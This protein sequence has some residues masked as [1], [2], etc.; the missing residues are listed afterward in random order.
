MS[1]AIAYEVT[2]PVMA[3][4][5]EVIPPGRRYTDPAEIPAGVATRR[6]VV[7]ESPRLARVHPGSFDDVPEVASE[8][9][10]AATAVTA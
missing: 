10:A 8:L 9:A 3:G 2:Q 7:T 5:R 1:D 4:G 6:V